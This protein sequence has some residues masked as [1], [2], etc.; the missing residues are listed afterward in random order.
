MENLT[1]EAN[2]NQS[3]DLWQAEVLG[4]IYETN[5]NEIAEWINE[6]AIQSSDRVRRGNLRWI[7]AGKVPAFVPFFNARENGVRLNDV[8]INHIQ[9][10]ENA[11]KINSTD[12]KNCF[13]HEQQESAFKCEICGNNYCQDCFPDE[14]NKDCPICGAFCRSL[15]F[16]DTNL[17]SPDQYTETKSF[18]SA[19]LD[20]K[21]AQKF[22]SPINLPS[23]VLRNKTKGIGIFFIIFFGLSISGLGSYLWAYKYNLVSESVLESLPEVAAL[24]TKFKT[25]LERA[26]KNTEHRNAEQARKGELKKVNENQYIKVRIGQ[27]TNLTKDVNELDDQSEINKFARAETAIKE[28]HSREREKIMS[29]YRDSRSKQNFIEV[30]V[31]L[32]FISFAGLFTVRYFTKK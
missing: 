11:R 7:N 12:L 32:F 16:L 1:R 8:K 15:N 9:F 2:Q 17:K 27:S 13:I 31:G 24:D 29:D 26:M 21:T 18:D 25:D 10:S 20:T 14:Q 22:D 23:Y 19:N 30:F 3:N 6:G 28:S 5:F 4:H